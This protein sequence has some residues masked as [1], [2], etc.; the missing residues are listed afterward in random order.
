MHLLYRLNKAGLYNILIAMVIETKRLKLIPL[1][2]EQF[3]LL[4]ESIPQLEN[5]MCLN[6]SNEVFDTHLQ[7]AMQFMYK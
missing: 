6:P 3:S 7:Q 5:I 1:N 2:L 4:L